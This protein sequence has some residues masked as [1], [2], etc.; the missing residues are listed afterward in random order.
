M[1]QTPSSD[2]G[3]EGLAGPWSQDWARGRPARKRVGRL[4]RVLGTLIFCLSSLRG[5]E[6]SNSVFTSLE[7]L[8]RWERNKSN[9]K[10]HVSWL[11][12]QKTK[13]NLGNAPSFFFFNFLPS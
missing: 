3:P 12:K 10:L 9:A 2:Q 7:V 4:R 6:R 11:R 5:C 13:H 1:L 8:I